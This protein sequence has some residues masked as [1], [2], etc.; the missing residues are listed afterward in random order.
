MDMSTRSETGL[1]PEGV[2]R[3]AVRCRTADVHDR[4][5]QNLFIKQSHDRVCFNKSKNTFIGLFKERLCLSFDSLIQRFSPAATS[6]F[7]RRNKNALNITVNSKS[8]PNKTREKFNRTT[9]NKTQ[10]KETRGKN[11]MSQS[12]KHLK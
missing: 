8:L 6:T 5:V 2:F 9:E 11:L 1:P 7:V 10:F 3:S 12:L 4:N